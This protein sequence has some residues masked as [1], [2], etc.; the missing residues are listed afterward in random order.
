MN[1]NDVLNIRWKGKRYYQIA[2]FI[3]ADKF[4]MA[5]REVGVPDSFLHISKPQLE[6]AFFNRT[7]KLIC[8]FDISQTQK[9]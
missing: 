8:W 1:A 4:Y 3:F 5:Y 6:E 7:A 9:V 2:Q